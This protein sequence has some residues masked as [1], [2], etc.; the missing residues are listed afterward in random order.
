MPLSDVLLVLGTFLATFLLL[1]LLIN[2][3]AAGWRR[4]RGGRR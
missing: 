2:A 4:R 1:S 3:V